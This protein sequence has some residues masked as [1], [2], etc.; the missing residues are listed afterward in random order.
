M[1]QIIKVVGSSMEDEYS[2][3]DFILVIKSPFLKF[4]LKPGRDVVFSKKVYGT[5]IKR[6]ESINADKTLNLKGLNPMSISRDLL[7][8]IPRRSVR[9]IVVYKFK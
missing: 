3:G 8:N 1:L 2:N 7:K 6:I 5:M 4:L 9:G